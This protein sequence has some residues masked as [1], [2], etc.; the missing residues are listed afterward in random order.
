MPLV[1]YKRFIKCPVLVSKLFPGLELALAP[2]STFA[3]TPNL[4]PVYMLLRQVIETCIKYTWDHLA[5]SKDDINKS[6]LLKPQNPN[7][8]YNT[9][10]IEYYYFC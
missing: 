10:Y 9:L 5:G 2:E 7:F 4:A 3:P 1:N 8:Y 6:K